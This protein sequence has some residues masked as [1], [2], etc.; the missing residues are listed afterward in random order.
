MRL[1]L[2][3]AFHLLPPLHPPPTSLHTNPFLSGQDHG[4]YRV[5]SGDKVVQKAGCE[6]TRGR[7][8]T[9]NPWRITGA[10]CGGA[11]SVMRVCSPS[12]RSSPIQP[13]GHGFQPRKES[14]ADQTGVKMSLEQPVPGP[15][16]YLPSQCKQGWVISS[17]SSLLLSLS[18]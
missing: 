7:L 5:G 11:C 16:C 14:C 3:L 12:S 17:P 1:C 4:P 18:Q 6:G 2:V 13:L 10:A 15:L 8:K 9:P